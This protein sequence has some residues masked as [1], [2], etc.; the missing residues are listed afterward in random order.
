MN[1][2]KKMKWIVSYGSE[3]IIVLLLILSN[4]YFRDWNGGKYIT[5]DGIGYY[6]HLPAVFIYQDISCDFLKNVKGYENS[7]HDFKMD[8]KQGRV[9]VNFA[10]VSLLWMPFFLLAHGLSFILGFATD[11]FAPLYQYSIA[12]AAIF[13][14]LTGL[15]ALRKLLT[16]YKINN[17]IIAF[18]QFLFVFATPLY[19]YTVYDASFTHVYSFSLITLFL[20]LLK[21]F[22]TNPRPALIIY[23][24]II[25]ALTSVIRPTNGI[26][27]VFFIPFAAGSVQTLKSGFRFLLRRYNYLLMGLLL[28]LPVFFYQLIFYYWQTGHFLVYSYG[29]NAVFNFLDPKISEILFSYE[30]GLFLYT[31]LLLLSLIGFFVLF[32]QSIFEGFSLLFVLVLVIYTMAS[33]YCWQMGMSFGNRGFVEFFQIF[34]ILF[35][36]SLQKQ[37]LKVPLI[38]ISLGL[39]VLNQIQTFQYTQYIFYWKMN[40]DMY[41]KVFLK[42]DKYYRGLLWDE[43]SIPQEVLRFENNVLDKKR[44]DEYTLRNMQSPSVKDTDMISTSN[45]NYSKELDKHDPY[46][47]I[48]SIEPDSRYFNKLNFVK[49]EASVYLYSKP[50]RSFFHLVC[51]EDTGNNQIMYVCQRGINLKQNE[52]NRVALCLNIPVLRFNNSKLSFYLSL[53]GKDKILVDSL[54]LSVYQ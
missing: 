3:T 2:L 22:F 45:I 11:G 9:I 40:K 16:L 54:K 28:C 46:S 20:L 4:L 39:L 29:S 26:F 25:L 12:A 44:M 35:A 50:D 17:G 36:L 51:E 14:L 18:V 38:V 8:T 13:Y 52:W 37:K 5:S 6:I 41:W 30:K 32:K 43:V 48:I 31:P 23:C 7:Q 27:S 21:R 1:A 15:I 49:A 33:W 24:C 10:G 53:Y 34:A 42:T 47:G 19:F